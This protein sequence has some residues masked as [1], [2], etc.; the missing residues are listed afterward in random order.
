MRQMIT[1]TVTLNGEDEKIAT[2]WAPAVTM[3]PGQHRE[4]TQ[5]KIRKHGY[6]DDRETRRPART[7]MKKT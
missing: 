1:L 6:M 4:S 3:L 5:R 2:S 7:Q